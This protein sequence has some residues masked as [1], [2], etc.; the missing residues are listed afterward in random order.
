MTAVTSMLKCLSPIDPSN[1]EMSSISVSP[2]V[3][4]SNFDKFAMGAKSETF[5]R[6]RSRTCKLLSLANGVKSEASVS[7]RYEVSRRRR[8]A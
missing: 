3:R 8:E 4:Y 1:W 6:A 7:H 2:S 5:A